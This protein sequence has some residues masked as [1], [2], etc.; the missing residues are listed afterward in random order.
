MPHRAAE[1]P[2]D[3][4]QRKHVIAAK[5]PPA[6]QQ[7]S[8]PAPDAAASDAA[9]GGLEGGVVGGEVGGKE[10]GRIGG[11][12]DAPVREDQVAHPPTVVSR[13]VPTYPAMAR[14]RGIEGRVLLRAIVDRDGHVEPA[15]EVIESMAPFDV[16][17]VDAL[18]QWHFHPGSD[19]DGKTVRVVVEVPMRFQLR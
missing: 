6:A 14:A 18:R 5:K 9:V 7:A 3:P 1:K 17:A 13:V 12:G 19:A 15:V 16:P 4:P 8:P 11:Q 10:G 2:I